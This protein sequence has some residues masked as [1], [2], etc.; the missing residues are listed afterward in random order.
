MY[1]LWCVLKVTGDSFPP[2][3]SNSSFCFRRLAPKISSTFAPNLSELLSSGSSESSLL[4]TRL[5]CRNR[6][7]GFPS[8]S[9]DPKPNCGSGI[10]S[11]AAK[12]ESPVKPAAISERSPRGPPADCSWRRKVSGLVAKFRCS[13]KSWLRK[14]AY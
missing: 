6:L 7:S 2:L 9:D 4:T 12:P 11:P 1:L 14:I 8:P 10:P 13:A 3:V 5:L